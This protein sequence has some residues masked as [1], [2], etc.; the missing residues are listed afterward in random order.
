M[1]Q[2][3]RAGSFLLQECHGNV[4]S[5]TAA[6]GSSCL[7]PH[8]HDDTVR[9][10][11]GD[12]K[13]FPAI[14]QLLR[15]LSPGSSVCVARVEDLFSEL[16]YGN[17]P[18]VA[19]H[20]DDKVCADVIHG[21]AW[22]LIRVSRPTFLGFGFCLW[23]LSS[24]PNFASSTISR[25]RARATGPAL[26]DDTCFSSAPPCELGHVLRDV[27]LRVLFLRLRHGSTAWILLCRVDVKDD[28]RQVPV[29]LA[30]A[31]TFGYVAGGH[32]VVD[33]CLQFGWRNS[34]GFWG[35]G[36]SVLE[37]SHSLHISRRYGVP[38]GGCRRARLSCS[39]AGLAAR[40]PPV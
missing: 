4:A 9:H 35:L 23:L 6:V 29:D 18:S 22:F 32:V 34:P 28:V 3:A 40:V 39:V 16:A 20:D 24:N 25:L 11:F 38:A 26:N 15:V 12:V 14:F 21:R 36:S 31:P 2:L 30:G 5:L 19:S 13:K 7:A 8:I 1:Y 27:L 37:H 10:W 17:H 33:L